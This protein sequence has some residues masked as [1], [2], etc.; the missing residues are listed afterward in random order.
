MTKKASRTTRRASHC[1]TTNFQC[2]TSSEKPRANLCSVRERSSNGSV[3][4]RKAQ[5]RTKPVNS[6]SG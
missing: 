6:V 1:A 5:N 4:Q 2:F 3:R